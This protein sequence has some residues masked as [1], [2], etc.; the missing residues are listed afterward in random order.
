MRRAMV[1]GRLTTLLLLLAVVASACALISPAAPQ[2]APT[3]SP[4]AT[5]EPAASTPTR[6]PAP[7]PPTATPLP[8][9]ATPTASS[10]TVVVANTDGQGVYLRASKH[11][12]DR[13][14]AYPDGAVLIVRGAAEDGDGLSWLPVRAPDGAEGWVPA[15]Y[16]A[17]AP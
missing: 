5:G 15:Q 9:S 3:P 14:G 11:V 1:V 16:T 13:L 4:A 8:P 12:P 7:P 2:D 17:P 10:A 6:A